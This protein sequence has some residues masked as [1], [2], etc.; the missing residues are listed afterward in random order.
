MAREVQD[1]YFKKAK[2]EGYVSRAAFKL[3][4]ID[5]RKRVLRRGDFVLDCGAA[6]GSWLQVAAERVGPRGFVV[7]V[8][9]KTF[10]H[11]FPVAN[12]RTITGDVTTMPVEALLR[13]GGGKQFDVVLSDMAP[14]TTGDRMSDH[15]L[16]VRLCEA[17]LQRCGELLRPGGT[18]VMKVFEGEAYPEL[19]KAAGRMFGEAKGFKPKASRSESPEMY[20]VGKGFR[21]AYEPPEAKVELPKR[22][23]KAEW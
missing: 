21:K 8:D 18:M 6:P 20:I 9:L 14:D 15:H 17:V 4:E 19:L 12:V 10:R 23:R 7:G 16:S 5:E 3:M 22:K 1:F 13:D 11:S 2:A